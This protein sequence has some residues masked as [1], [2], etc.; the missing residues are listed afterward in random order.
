MRELLSLNATPA[1]QALKNELIRSNKIIRA[2]MDRAERSTSVQGTDFSLFQT[3]II[4]EEQV[5]S[6]TSELESALRENE[7]ITR[8]LRE[9]ETRFRGLVSQSLVGIAILKEGR[10]SY[11]NAKFDVIFGYS[12]EEVRKLAPLDI[13]ATEDRPLVAENIRKRISGEVEQVKYV[14]HGVRKDGAVIDVEIQ[15]NAMEIG[16]KRELISL[17]MDVTER[18]RAEREV[19]ALQE[20][21]REQ[22]TRDALTGLYNRRYLEDTLSRELILAERK[23][24]PVSVIMGDLDHFKAVN[25]RYGHLGGDE[26]LRHFG[27][28]LKGHVRGSDIYCRYGGEEFLLVLPQMS[29]TDAV[30]RA[31]QL[32]RAISSAPVLYGASP[33]AVTA[34][35]GVATFPYDGKSG[36]ALIA[37]ADSALYEAKASGRNRVHAYEPLVRPGWV[38]AES[39]CS[40]V[41][42][43]ATSAAQA[44]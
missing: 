6:R 17:F 27:D 37:S 34:S 25:D 41:A 12:A 22:A 10:I 13:V 35:F 2:L 8:A 28:L 32:R 19:Q 1:E 7:K 42:G 38:A 21:L 30:A 18:T 31:E 40:R 29:K 33:I 26:V 23:S 36:D 9:S 20:Q 4:L 14:F 5:R 39:D 16:G 15:G 43:V 11:S 24:H 3:A 44:R